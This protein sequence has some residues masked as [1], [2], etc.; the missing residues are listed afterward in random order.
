MAVSAHR[1]EAKA[2]PRSGLAA[3]LR[4]RMEAGKPPIRVGLIGSGEMGTDIVT[5]CAQ[6]TGITVAAIAD[7]NLDSA[8]RARDHC[9]RS[10]RQDCHGRRQAGL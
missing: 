7:I 6:M 1:D 3:D 4:Q 8:K 5:Q 9:R 2:R 10:R